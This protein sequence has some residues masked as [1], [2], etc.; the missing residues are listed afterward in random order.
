[1]AGIREAMKR[2]M[3]GKNLGHV[4]A[5]GELKEAVKCTC[6]EKSTCPLCKK[7]KYIIIRLEDKGLITQYDYGADIHIAKD[8]QVR[9]YVMLMIID[10][11][12]AEWQKVDLS[13]NVEYVK[14]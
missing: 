12:N 10:N 8:V 4:V 6:E 9:D 14:E 2:V 11:W 1:M 13:R 7:T 3:D 5:M